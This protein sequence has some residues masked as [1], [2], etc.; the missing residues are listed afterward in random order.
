MT[1]SQ[2]MTMM[3]ALGAFAAVTFV[4]RHVVAIPVVGDYL[5]K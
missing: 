3:L 2:L 1:K 5:P 4:Q